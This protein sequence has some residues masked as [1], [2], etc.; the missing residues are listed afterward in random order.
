MECGQT[1][2]HVDEREWSEVG[3]GYDNR[4]YEWLKLRVFRKEITEIGRSIS[5]VEKDKLSNHEG[6][7]ARA[8]LSAGERE[9]A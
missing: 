5:A 6:E 9:T 8:E 7:A 2:E 4:M 1:R 3:R